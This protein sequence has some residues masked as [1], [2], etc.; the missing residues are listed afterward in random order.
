M[1][2]FDERCEELKADGGILKNAF[3][4]FYYKPSYVKHREDGPSQEWTNGDNY[5]YYNGEYIMYI[6][7]DATPEQVLEYRLKIL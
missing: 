5:W 1:K 7:G 3:G 6:Y 4:T 2:I